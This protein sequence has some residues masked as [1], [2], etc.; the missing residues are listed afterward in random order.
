VL[1]VVLQRAGVDALTAQARASAFDTAY[2]WALGIAALT[3]IPCTMLL[4]AER[5]RDPIPAHP[6]EGLAADADGA[7]HPERVAE[8]VG[9]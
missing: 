1:A 2:W 7:P 5:P 9:V 3:L 4:R 8:P 6:G